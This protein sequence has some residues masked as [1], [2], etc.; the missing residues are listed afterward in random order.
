VEIG[1]RLVLTPSTI[2]KKSI[3]YVQSA[4]KRT[5]K[6]HQKLKGEFNNF[7]ALHLMFSLGPY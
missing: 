6:A 5:F 4:F 7:E 1:K 3:D 2:P